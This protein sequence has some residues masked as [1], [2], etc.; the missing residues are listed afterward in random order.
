MKFK[1][2]IKEGY[3]NFIGNEP[4][5]LDKKLKW[6]DQV[7]DM[8]QAAY[9]DI[10]GIKGSGFQDKNDMIQNIP[11]WKI[12]YRGEQLIAVVLYKDTNGRK[13]VALGTDK[14]KQAKKILSDIFKN[15]LKVSYGE[16]SGKLLNLIIKG[17]SY[18]RLEPYLLEPIYVQKLL[19]KQIAPPDPEK[20][21][22]MDLET[23]NKF[24]KLHKYFYMRDFNGKSYLKICLG[25][26]HLILDK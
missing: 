4:D 22:A 16:Y 15:A 6:A 19:D 1:T 13:L 20:L 5:V 18:E 9:D 21:N 10:G 23:Y 14:S 25:T 24:P 11:F 12:F 26:P 7:W 3:S 17:V 2:Y 8:L